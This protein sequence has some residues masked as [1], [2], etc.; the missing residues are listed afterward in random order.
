VAQLVKSGKR[1]DKL[2]L[3]RVLHAL[4]DVHISLKEFSK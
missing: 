4:E 2:P 3:E 1:E